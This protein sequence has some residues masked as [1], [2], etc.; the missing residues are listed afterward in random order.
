MN[1]I[2]RYEAD[3]IVNRNKENINHLPEK[4]RFETSELRFW[5][6]LADAYIWIAQVIEISV[7]IWH[8]NKDC[9]A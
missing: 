2:I 5:L 9:I 3:N 6:L 1:T 8:I 7:Q 4:R